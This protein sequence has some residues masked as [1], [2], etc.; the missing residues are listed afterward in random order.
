MLPKNI[1]KICITYFTYFIYEVLTS[2]GLYLDLPLPLKPYVP[3]GGTFE[4]LLD[5][6]C[7]ILGL[8]A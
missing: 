7:L 4:R 2:Y 8:G 6:G 3:I 1:V 5:H